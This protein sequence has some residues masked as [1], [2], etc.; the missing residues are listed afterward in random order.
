MKQL[1]IEQRINAIPENK[2]NI[3][4]LNSVLRKSKSERSRLVAKISLKTFDLFCKDQGLERH[5]DPDIEYGYIPK[6]IEQFKTWYNPKPDPNVLVRPDIDSICKTLDNFVGFMDADR[7]DIMI[8][9]KAH[10]KKKSPKTIKLYFGFVKSYLRKVHSI[11]LSVEDI[12]DFVTFPDQVK[13]QREP[14]TLKQLK[15]IMNHASPIQKA[16]YYVLISSG[17]RLGEALTLTKKNL[18]MDENPVRIILSAGN[19]KTNQGRECFISSEA[20]EKLKPILESVTD[21]NQTFFMQ[22]KNLFYQVI[23]E[24]RNFAYL[25]NKLGMTEKYPDSVR[26]R[27]SIHGFRAYFHTKA[28]QTHSTE[29][30]NALDGHSGYLEQYYR[31]TPEKRAEMYKQLEPE[32]FI[33]SLKVEADKT[34]DKIIDTLQEQMLKL[35]DEMSRLQKTQ[36]TRVE[37]KQ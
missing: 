21:D 24:D 22:Q 1:L 37:V 32:L 6:M 31:L 26:Y 4:W 8:S 30:A 13:E 17:M 7:P 5:P 28:S 34:K 10:F 16:L 36:E 27:V 14:L 12:K 23:K 25:R 15:M 3:D 19:T 33:E 11:K 18:R 29:Y 2:A 35:Q 20:V 9:D